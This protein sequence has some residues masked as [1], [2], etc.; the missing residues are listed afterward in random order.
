MI[1]GSVP[2]RV[3]RRLS[4]GGSSSERNR[5]STSHCSSVSPCTRYASA[6]TAR[7]WSTVW[8]SRSATRSTSRI[9]A[10]MTGAGTTSVTPNKDKSEELHLVG[11]VSSV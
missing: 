1:D 3:P 11:L 6:H 5:R 4:V 2:T 9:S 10:G 8:I 7:A